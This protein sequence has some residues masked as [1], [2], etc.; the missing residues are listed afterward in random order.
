MEKSIVVEQDEITKE[1]SKSFDYEFNGE[2]FFKVPKLP[3]LPDE[4]GIGLI[5]GPS[6]SGKSSLL[7]QFGKEECIEWDLNKA[8]CS[9]FNNA[10]EA[11]NRLSAVGFNSIP[12]WMRPYHVLSTGEKFRADLSRRLKNNAIIDEFT[13]VVDRT[14]AKSCSNAVRRYVDK[15]NFKNIIIATCHYDIAEWLQPDWI[16]DTSTNRL[17]V[18]RGL[19]RR[20][21]IELEI[22]PCS[23]ETWKMFCNHHYMSGN[24]NKSSRCWIAI[25]E[26]KIVGFTATLPLPNG[27][28]KNAWREHRTVIMPDYQGLGLGVRLSDAIAEIH[29]QNNM[30]YY[31]KTAHKRLGEYRQSKPFWK[32]TMHN[33]KD[34][35]NSYSNSIK[36]NDNF[37]SNDLLQKHANRVCYCHEYIGVK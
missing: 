5:V 37:Y 3:K 30:K 17:I 29:I 22:L 12:S 21:K 18:G 9:H 24:I 20:P 7:S 6:G 11:E 26:G 23:I 36:N 19:V 13:S 8:I 31:S 25:W 34:R 35:N 27:A 16:F 28:L 1:I 32:A 33:M 14:V 10:Q 2:S 4:F 15:E